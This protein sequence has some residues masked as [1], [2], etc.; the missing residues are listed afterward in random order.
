LPAR[1]LRITYIAMW[2][3]TSRRKPG[4]VSLWPRVLDVPFRWPCVSKHLLQSRTTRV[5]C[6]GE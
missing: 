6:D 3:T 5:D 2:W 4:D 1:K